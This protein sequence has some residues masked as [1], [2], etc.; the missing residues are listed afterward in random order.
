MEAIEYY[1]QRKFI[2]QPKSIPVEIELKESTK[3]CNKEKHD[4]SCH[5]LI[6]KRKEKIPE[7][8]LLNVKIKVEEVFFEGDGIVSF[9]N[10]V[11]DGYEI[12]IEFVKSCDPFE[13]KMTLQICQIKDFIESKTSKENENEKTLNWIKLNASSF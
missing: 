9:C 12:G 13:V 7:K 8:Q 10:K 4:L 1:Q 11:K 6:I 2:K 3:I 5:G